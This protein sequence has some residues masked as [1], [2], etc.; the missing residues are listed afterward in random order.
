MKQLRLSLS[1]VSK[2]DAARSVL[3]YLAV[4]VLL[5]T[6]AAGGAVAIA[7]HKMVTV[8]VDGQRVP[9]S[10][11]AGT[12][13]AAL[14]QLGYAPGVRD[15]VSPAADVSL[16]DGATITLDRARAVDLIVDGRGRRVWATGPT[17]AKALDQLHI[18]PDDY[19]S[20]GR[21][22]L[23]PLD[24]A[25]LVVSSPRTET[26]VDG[27]AAP[28]PMRAAG[29]TVGE[30]LASA[31]IPL[32]QDDS[33]VPAAN[34]P[35]ADGMRI[36]VTRNRTIEQT[37]QVPLPSS[38]RV[39]LD[40][41]MNKDRRTKVSPG[42]PGEQNTT[43]RV[44]MVNGRVVERSPIA[45]QVVAPARP[46][47]VR[48]GDK[49]GTDVPPEPDGS[50]FDAISGCES[51]HNWADNTGNG[52]YGGIQFDLNTWAR[53]G[54]LRYAPRPDLAT[55]EEQ[56]AIGEKT[57]ARQGWGAWPACTAHLGIR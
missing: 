16:A 10:T 13:R 41:G 20:Q 50:V 21:S 18:P 28:V 5:S 4:F 56:I 45:S 15:T 29:P 24:G 36:T 27:G 11:M 44:R 3:L 35:L 17:V 1:V 30:F 32:V 54:G 52:Y 31:G 2:L 39:I 34:T 37:M 42:A 46:G 33:A 40:P 8:V 9:L 19:V 55:R 6:L 47:V 48:K 7:V 25:V 14:A 12:V 53:Q 57:L 26:V 51:H 22:D 23:L 43:Y 38:D 49:P